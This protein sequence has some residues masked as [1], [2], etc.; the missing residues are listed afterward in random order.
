MIDN[1]KRKMGGT[2]FK[3]APGG[4]D[5]AVRKRCA[6]IHQLFQLPCTL[7]ADD[8]GSSL[9]EA[10]ED[11]LRRRGNDIV[12]TLMDGFSVVQANEDLGAL[13]GRERGGEIRSAVQVD[14]FDEA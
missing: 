5:A 10:G 7:V 8:V 1:D 2:M 3:P 14:P 4:Y 6:M 12:E 9:P 13:V 11:F